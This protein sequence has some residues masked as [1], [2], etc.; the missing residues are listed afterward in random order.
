MLLCIFDAYSSCYAASVGLICFSGKFNV[1]IFLFVFVC[2]VLTMEDFEKASRPDASL[3]DG[4]PLQDEVA[5]LQAMPESNKNRNR[6]IFF[7]HV[8]L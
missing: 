2:Q 4:L 5:R 6:L 1:C 7:V 8:L 3:D